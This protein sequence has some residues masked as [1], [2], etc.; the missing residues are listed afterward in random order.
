MKRD[1]LLERLM[2]PESDE[3]PEAV[4]AEVE[5]PPRKEYDIDVS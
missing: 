4:P 3:Q 2:F 1:D 5:A